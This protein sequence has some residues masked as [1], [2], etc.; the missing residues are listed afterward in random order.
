MLSHFEKSGHGFRLGGP[1]ME[2]GPTL[3]NF[4]TRPSATK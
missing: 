3:V 4:A 2:N 1:T